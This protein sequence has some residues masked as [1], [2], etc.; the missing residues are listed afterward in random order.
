[1]TTSSGVKMAGA[2]RAKELSKTVSS[3]SLPS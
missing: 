1:L 2:P 3:I